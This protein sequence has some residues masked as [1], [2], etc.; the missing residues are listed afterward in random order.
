MPEKK[1]DEKAKEPKRVPCLYC[2]AENPEDA[3]ACSK[4]GIQLKA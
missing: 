3:A 2:K 1:D 4:C